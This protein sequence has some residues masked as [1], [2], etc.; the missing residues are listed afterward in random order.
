MRISNEFYDLLKLIAIR[1]IPA[2]DT[3]ILTVGKIWGLPYYAEIGATV[4]AIGVFLAIVLGISNA[5]YLA[6]IEA[7]I[8]YEDKDTEVEDEI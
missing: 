1:V 6:D 7:G 2:L 8:V 5:T 4:A 3:L